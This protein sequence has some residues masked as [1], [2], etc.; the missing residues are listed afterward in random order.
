MQIGPLVS[1]KK[2]EIVHIWYDLSFSHDANLLIAPTDA[3]T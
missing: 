2:K 1:D 3:Y